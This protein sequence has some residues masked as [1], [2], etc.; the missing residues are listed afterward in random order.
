MGSPIKRILVT[1]GAG[2]IGTNLCTQ[3][4][5]QGEFVLC[6]DNFMTGSMA[7][8][9][10]LLDDP[11]FQ[12][13]NG[14]V[15][16]QIELQN[17]K[18]IYHLACP[19]SPK[20]YQKDPIHTIKT[21]VQGTLNMLELAKKEQCPILFSSTSEIYGEPLVHPQPEEY[22]G[23]VNTV[24]PRSCYDEGKRLAE[25]LCLS[26][27]QMFGVD[28]K[29][30][31]IFNTYGPYLNPDDGRVVSNFIT[32]ALKGEPLTVYGEGTQTR[33]FCFVSDTVEGLMKMMNSSESGPINIG[34]PEEIT[35]NQLASIVAKLLNTKVVTQHTNLPQN[36]PTRR[37]PDI[38]KAKTCLNWAPS[39]SLQQ[40]LQKTIDYFKTL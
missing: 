22:F 27:R 10:H 8:L 38:T 4:I 9:S 14:D 36:D 39:T 7:N 35:V 3:L 5:K 25:T 17:I 23:N 26:Y 33:S 15:I 19:A 18:A 34:N 21:C 6:L 11:H 2:L 16:N 28:A 30:V 12:L 29:I 13:L 37:K 40:G 20:Y 32:Q 24:G 1:G 31:R